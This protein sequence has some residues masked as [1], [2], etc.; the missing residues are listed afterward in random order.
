MLAV[1]LWTAIRLTAVDA[2]VTAP[3]GHD[4]NQRLLDVTTPL[5]GAPYRLSALGEGPD[6]AD[7]ID[8]DPRF[9]IDAFDCTTFVETAMALASST[10]IRSAQAQL[11]RIRYDGAPSYA[12]RRH[13][14]EAE[15][16]PAM[17]AMHLLTDVTRRVGS[18]EVVVENLAVWKR[19]KKKGLPPLTDDR[20]PTITTSIDV[21]PIAAALAHSERIPP[22]TVVSVVRV[23]R[24]T[25]PVRVSHQGLVLQKTVD[26]RKILF[27]RHAADRLHHH[28]VDE[29]IDV[30]LKRLLGHKEW[31]VTGIHL[32]AFQ[33]TSS[34]TD[35]MPAASATGS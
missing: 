35:A 23:D 25:I 10:S 18:S 20:I 30:Y 1:W 16:L 9:R 3:V 14:P 4:A 34:T 5:L 22:G 24:D 28:V 2:A 11:D 8:P 32:D 21:W 6:G 7:R 31:P 15:W 12:A 29:P 27:I 19:G 26:G 13:F 17:R 33:I